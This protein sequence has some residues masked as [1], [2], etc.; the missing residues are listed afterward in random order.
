MRRRIASLLTLGALLVA[1][2]GISAPSASA[3]TYSSSVKIKGYNLGFFNGKV[4]SE[5]KKCKKKR[6]VEVYSD[7]QPPDTDSLAAEATT[8]KKGKWD[9]VDFHGLG[10]DYYAIVKQKSGK[11]Y[12]CASATS[13]IFHR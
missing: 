6:K 7:Q 3:I 4:G 5:F 9:A 13:P 10:G 1:F 12:D 8:N 11:N 2:A